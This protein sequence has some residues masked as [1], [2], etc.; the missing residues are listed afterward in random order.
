MGHIKICMTL[1]EVKVNIIN[2]SCILMS[3]AVT[4]PSL[5]MTTIMVSEES[6]ARDRQTNRHRDTHTHTDIHTH[7]QVSSSTLKFSK[8]LTTLQ[9]TK[10]CFKRNN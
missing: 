10:G 1:N 5:V 6:L 8:S 3:E 2:M 7:A 4:V 9:T